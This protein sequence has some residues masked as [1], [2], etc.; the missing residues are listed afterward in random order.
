MSELYSFLFCIALGFCARLLYIASTLL[1]KRTDIMP[2][3]FIL[4]MSVCLTVG[5]AFA[6]YIIFTDSVI[7]PYM[8]A[9]MFAGYFF[10][11]KFTV[12]KT[13]RTKK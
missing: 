7:A 6:A 2:V 11:Y 13:P 4:D 1:A 3:T 5:C 9:A 12:S 8:F 10:T